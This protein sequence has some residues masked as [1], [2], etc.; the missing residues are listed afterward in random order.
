MEEIK[1]VNSSVF[2]NIQPPDYKQSQQTGDQRDI[3][4]LKTLSAGE[5]NRSI[6]FDEQGLWIGGND[7][8]TAPFRIDIQGNQIYRDSET[9]R[10][11]IGQI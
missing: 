1:I 4:N 5:G 10:M 8:S 6:H 11:V 9:N 3:G 2:T 7:F